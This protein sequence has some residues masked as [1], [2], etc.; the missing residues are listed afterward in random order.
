MLILR[1]ERSAEIVDRRLELASALPCLAKRAAQLLD[2]V[3]ELPNGLLSAASGC[4]QLI[5]VS[6]AFDGRR[7]V[8][9]ETK[10]SFRHRLSL[11][12]REKGV[13]QTGRERTL[14]NLLLWFGLLVLGR[15]YFAALQIKSDDR[16]QFP[17]FQGDFP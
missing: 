16:V 12:A 17:G 6:R 7:T 3:P 10:G 13:E 9:L 5:E 4:R 1:A 2:L 15:Q 8:N 14:G 11:L